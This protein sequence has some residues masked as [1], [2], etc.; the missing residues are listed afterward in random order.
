MGVL[1]YKDAVNDLSAKSIPQAEP[2]N[3]ITYISKE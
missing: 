1:P 2:N 3:D